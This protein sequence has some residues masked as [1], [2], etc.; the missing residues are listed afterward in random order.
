MPESE[1]FCSVAQPGISFKPRCRRLFYYRIDSGAPDNRT[2]YS[3]NVVHAA[4][5]SPI[6][7]MSG[8]YEGNT[9]PLLAP[10]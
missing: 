7:P 5:V 8:S 2:T 10:A 4:V 1:S 3:S 6:I 9:L